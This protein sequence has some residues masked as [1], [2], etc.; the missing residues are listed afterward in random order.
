MGK[1]TSLK[2]LFEFYY[3]EF[4]PIYAELAAGNDYPIQILNEVN[5][6]FDHL[7]RLWQYGEPESK[8]VERVSG[9]L[10]RGCFDCFKV[11][12]KRTADL[13]DRLLKIDTS[14]IDNGSFDRDM[15]ALWAQIGTLAVSARTKEGDSRSDDVASWHDAFERWKEVYVGCK[16]FETD[17][18]LNAKVSWAEK[19]QVDTAQRLEAEIRRKTGW[20]IRFEGIAIGVLAGVLSCA[21]WSVIH[22]RFASSH[23]PQDAAPPASLSPRG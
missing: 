15:H 20:K 14:I 12:L 4:K 21:I 2:G 23:P 19:K 13:H 8:T 10:K 7:S 17:F 18:F 3:E 5:A 22:E 6:A 1:P 9:H 11:I 16:K